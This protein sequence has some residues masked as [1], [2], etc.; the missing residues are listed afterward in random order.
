MGVLRRIWVLGTVVVLS[1]CGGGGGSTDV[2]GAD[3]G[4]GDAGPD[5]IGVLCQ[6]DLDCADVP[7]PTCQKAVCEHATGTCTLIPDPNL[8]GAACVP[9]DDRCAIGDG[10]CREGS[11]V[12]AMERNCDDQD[13]CTEDSCNRATGVCDHAPL[14]QTPCDDGN[15]CT[16]DDRCQAGTCTPGAQVCQCTKDD[17]CPV[18]EDH[19]LGRLVCNTDRNTCEVMPG[20]AVTCE[21][22][23]NPCLE[24]SCDPQNGQCVTRNREDGSGC[25]DEDACTI[26]D[27]CLQGTCGGRPREC[28]DHNDYTE[29]LCDPSTGQCIA[30]N[31]SD[32]PC[33]DGDL[34]TTGERC[35]EGVCGLGTLIFGCCIDDIDCE[36]AFGCSQKACVNHQCVLTP[37]ECPPG[38]DCRPSTCRGDGQCASAPVFRRQRILDVPFAGIFPP[39]GVRLDPS[40]GW[41]LT[42]RGILRHA[43]SPA[44]RIH[45]PPFRTG[46][47]LNYLAVLLQGTGARL[48]PFVQGNLS[49]WEFHDD[50]LAMLALGTGAQEVVL[51]VPP[52]VR[53]LRIQ[54]LHFPRESCQPTA[55]VVVDAPVVD[56][57]MVDNGQGQLV[58]GYLFQAGQKYRF[59]IQSFDDEGQSLGPYIQVSEEY[60]TAHPRFRVQGEWAGDR[61]VLLY[62][63]VEVGGLIRIRQVEYWNGQVLSTGFL[64]DRADGQYQPALAPGPGDR[65][66]CYTSSTIDG[67]GTGI[68]CREGTGP[69]FA[70][71]ARTSGDQFDPDVTRFADGRPLVVWAD[72]EG[73]IRGRVHDPEGPG[74]FLVQPPVL[75]GAT[76]SRPRV[77][78]SGNSAMVV[79]EGTGV[80]G[81]D[82][83]GVFG[84]AIVDGLADPTMI[85]FAQNL[86]GDQRSPEVAPVADG[87]LVTFANDAAGEIWVMRVTSRGT[88]TGK[89][90]V[91]SATAWAAS[92]S[93]LLPID[94]FLCRIGF[95]DLMDKVHQEIVSGNCKEGWY[96][97]GQ[98]CIGPGY[99]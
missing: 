39:T 47:G 77:A 24:S 45:L 91:Q 92:P 57:G 93:L 66:V 32:T 40:E 48:V 94:P 50:S 79:F 60:P 3:P 10:Q 73:A 98:I 62:G 49:T 51:E 54:A 84:R 15:A 41:D 88:V 70:M 64:S 61:F 35:V 43:G 14:D 13:P 76:Y 87:Y 17:D 36:D 11:C 37:V 38:D 19:C 44:G 65:F 56:F 55:P 27:I 7:A 53:I 68:A 71:N 31:L 85:V 95:R 29:D 80:P 58:A 52:E 59:A 34:C 67:L 28:D 22:P 1:G 18:P 25:D 72:D 26:D 83:V 4:P 9:S 74:E 90:I 2:L 86:I 42:P 63:A 20:T 75:G 69:W 33:N 6:R 8:E 21:A 96:A 78:T 46:T 82:G 99:R 30:R 16:A 81:E 89:Q 97:N 23:A 5:G 12:P